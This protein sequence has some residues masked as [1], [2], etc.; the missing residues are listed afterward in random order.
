MAT[1]HGLNYSPSVI[2]GLLPCFLLYF[3]SSFFNSLLLSPRSHQTERDQ[4]SASL[5]HFMPVSHTTLVGTDS[6][7]QSPSLIQKG[8]FNSLLEIE[9][10]FL[11]VNCVDYSSSLLAWL[12][13]M[14]YLPQKWRDRSISGMKRWHMDDVSGS[15]QSTQ[16]GMRTRAWNKNRRE[17]SSTHFKMV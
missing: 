16:V 1:A 9:E 11:W 6:F 4:E 7:L 15:L 2:S 14:I 10:L 3:Y 17:F 12:S 8:S 5:D 13:W